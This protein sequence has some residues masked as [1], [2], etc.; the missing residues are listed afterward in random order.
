MNRPTVS[1]IIPVYN[2][3][4]YLAEAIESVLAQTYRPI[5]IIVVDD[6]S[7]DGSA[8]IAKGYGSPVRY[9]FQSNRGTGAARNRGVGLAVG[10]FLAFL[11]QDDL[12]VAD[13]LTVQ[14]EAFSTVS[15]LD[16]VFGH[17]KQFHSPELDERVKQRIYCPTEL[18]PGYSPSAM[19]IKRDAFLRV[20]LFDTKWQ[21]GEWVDWCVRAAELELKAMIL[22]DLVTWRR[23]HKGNKGVLQRTAITE[24]VW[25]LKASL[26]RR[27]TKGSID[28]NNYRHKC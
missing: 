12:W 27:H 10:N 6:G 3:E 14:M 17:I 2:G 15:E 5:E 24:Y 16:L 22:P 18:M 7:T 9:F 4:R 8:H 26:D 25:I 19:L 1:V 13:K 28:A 23:L 20:G 11:D 21:V